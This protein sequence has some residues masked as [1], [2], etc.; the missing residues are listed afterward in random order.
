MEGTGV[1]LETLG[2]RRRSGA[3]RCGQHDHVLVVEGRHTGRNRPSGVGLDQQGRARLVRNRSMAAVAVEEIEFREDPGSG[4]LSPA[5]DGQDALQGHSLADGP[6]PRGIHRRLALDIVGVDVVVLLEGGEQLELEGQPRVARAHHLMGDELVRLVAA[7]VAVQADVGPDDRILQ[8]GHALGD[9][10]GVA[11]TDGIVAGD[12]A[13][14]RP[15]AALAADAVRN[16]EPGPALGGG[17]RM[18][19]Q[20]GRGILGRAQTQPPR[21]GLGTGIGQGPPGPAVRAARTRRILPADQFV[22]AHDRPVGGLTTMAGRSGAGGD[23]F[24]H[25]GRRHLAGGG[26]GWQDKANPDAERQEQGRARP[27]HNRAETTHADRRRAQNVPTSPVGPLSRTPP[28][29]VS[30][31]ITNLSAGSPKARSIAAKPIPPASTAGSR[32][33]PRCPAGPR[34]ALSA[35]HVCHRGR[36]RYGGRNSPSGR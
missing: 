23:A 8:P 18:A 36:R 19:T 28:N 33:A 34:S 27:D 17:F 11:G 31:K 12:P 20:A 29:D 3:G 10:G 32:F 6:D 16:L 5:V 13:A 25:A 30:I 22:L 7:P 9:I 4:P 14:R 15:V 24:M 35:P 1:S 2:Q 26:P 21:D